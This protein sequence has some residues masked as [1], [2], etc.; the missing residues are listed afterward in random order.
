[1]NKNIEVGKSYKYIG[2]EFIVFDSDCCV[3]IG[4]SN[5][6]QEMYESIVKNKVSFDFEGN[7]SFKNGGHKVSACPIKVIKSN[8]TLKIVGKSDTSVKFELY[9][10]PSVN[11]SPC[12][13]DFE[14]ITTEYFSEDVID[15]L[16]EL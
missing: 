15:K 16:V 1:M 11:Y 6:A 4:V 13:D 9:N 7:I 12:F 2:K 3:P 8:A 14:V 10:N 5:T